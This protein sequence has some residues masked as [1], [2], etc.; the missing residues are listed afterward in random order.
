MNSSAPLTLDP[1]KL[2]KMRAAQ[3]NIEARQTRAM[4]LSAHIASPL[5]SYRD[6]DFR[7]STIA[8]R[9]NRSREKEIA[10]V[11]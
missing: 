10:S 11:G 4:A 8:D 5:A 6:T 3:C 9:R 2:L 7:D 1:D